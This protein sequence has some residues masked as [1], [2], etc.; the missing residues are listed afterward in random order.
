[1][2]FGRFKYWFLLASRFLAG[3]GVIQVIN[4]TTGLLLLRVL[5]VQEFALYSLAGLMLALA[6]LGSNLGLT[7]AFITLGAR[8]K[9]DPARLGS[10]FAT[11]RRRRVWLF[12][13]VTVV[14]LCLLPLVARGRG[15]GLLEI[16][17]TALLVVA[18]NW[19]QL[20]QSLRTCVMDVHHDAGGLWTSG[21]AGAGTRLLLTLLCCWRMPFATVALAI[22]LL[23]LLAAETVLIGRGR[24]YMTDHA[25]P[26]RRDA[27]RVK[28][29]VYPLAPSVIYYALRGQISLLL[30][31]LFGQT[32]SIAD[33]GAL[34]RLAQILGLVSLLSIFLVQPYFARITNKTNFIKKG[35]VVLLAYLLMAALLLASAH[36]MPGWWLLLLGPNY[37]GLQPLLPL[38]FSVPLLAMLGDIL[39]ILLMSRGWT[40][41]QNLTIYLGLSVQA[42][43][44]LTGRVDTA[45]GALLLSLYGF[46]TYVAVQLILLLKNLT[47]SN[48]DWLGDAQ[49]QTPGRPIS[50]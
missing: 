40:K 25:P 10:L 19:V 38:A 35:S 9:D 24:R 50:P 13:F 31:G 17:L 28:N 32:A 20:T 5:P 7:S 15:W 49:I 43:F 45:Y 27:E 42:L 6:S 39:Y 29:F 37:A 16:S 21:L 34:G 11:V 12:A 14:V 41:G 3:Q 4:L 26:D 44:I 47:R 33:L 18:S 2:R 36:V 8:V 30:L 46:G 48:F 1:M 22:N 23:G